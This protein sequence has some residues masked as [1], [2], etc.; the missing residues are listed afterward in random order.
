[1]RRSLLAILRGIDGRSIGRALAFLL[2]VNA[3]AAGFHTGAI[4]ATGTLCTA[5]HTGSTGTPSAPAY[6]DPCCMAGCAA[7]AVGLPGEAASIQPP[8]FAAAPAPGFAASSEAIAFR[9]FDHGP[10]GPP[11]LI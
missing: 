1:M 3:L 2:V 6:P 7:Q 10:R 9:L 5:F 11:F 4:A 8:E